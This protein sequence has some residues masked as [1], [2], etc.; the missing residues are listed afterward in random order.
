MSKENPLHEMLF[1]LNRTNALAEF[2]GKKKC[3]QQKFR[4]LC[5]IRNKQVIE[6][7]IANFSFTEAKPHKVNNEEFPYREKVNIRLKNLLEE[8]K[9]LHDKVPLYY[10]YQ[11]KIHLNI[12]GNDCL[13]EIR[14]EVHFLC[15]I[16]NEFNTLKIPLITYDENLLRSLEKAMDEWND[17]ELLL[18]FLEKRKAV[19]WKVILY[20]ALQEKEV[21]EVRVRNMISNIFQKV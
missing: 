17:I 9:R 2:L 15:L 12:I 3:F 14:K 13:P 8:F 11:D 16:K 19:K 4:I 5:K 7:L 20:R 21:A 10:A 1:L 6:R 18:L